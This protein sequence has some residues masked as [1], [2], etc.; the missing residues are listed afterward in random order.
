MLFCSAGTCTA[1]EL[2]RV[3]WNGD[4]GNPVDWRSYLAQP[5]KCDRLYIRV[6]TETVSRPSVFDGRSLSLIL[7]Q[8]KAN[9][10]VDVGDQDIR[11]DV[12]DD[13]LLPNIHPRYGMYVCGFSPSVYAVVNEKERQ[14]Y[15]QVIRS[16]DLL[17]RHPRQDAE[18]LNAVRR[19]MAGTWHWLELGEPQRVEQ[20]DAGEAHAPGDE[21]DEGESIDGE[22]T[23]HYI[24]PPAVDEAQ[25]AQPDSDGN[26][27]HCE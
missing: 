7:P 23:F 5:T 22:D 2:D 13:P 19:Q 18:S 27:L 21:N 20:M 26:M 16:G 14:R 1:A 25:A 8:E 10:R 3:K 4:R 6:E 11:A 15:Q 9:E 12:S 17:G 24:Q